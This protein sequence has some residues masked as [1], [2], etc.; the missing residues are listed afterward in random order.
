MNK[1]NLVSPVTLII[2][3]RPDTT[4]IVFRQIAKAKPS[5][6]FVVGDGA[7]TGFDD[8]VRKVSEARKIT[9]SVNWPCA[10]H[11]DFA[12]QN[13]GCKM[14]VVSGLN[15][16]FGMV[17]RTIILEDDVVP[18]LSFFRYCDELL[19]RYANDNRIGMI[20]G[21]N[22]LPSHD[23]VDD[24]SYIYS[25]VPNIPGWGTWARVWNSFDPGVK[26]W[27]VMKKNRVMNEFFFSNPAAAKHWTKIAE[28]VYAGNHQ[29]WDY[30]FS[31]HLFTNNLLTVIPKNNLISNI[32]HGPE[33]TNT[34]DPGDEFANQATV[35]IP[36]PLKHPL[37][38]MPNMSRESTL[39]RDVLG[40]RPTWLR[41]VNKGSRCVSHLMRREWDKLMKEFRFV[42][43]K[44]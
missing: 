24:Y 39:L 31:I 44:Q 13:L 26:L 41:I 20:T 21:T 42:F 10:V 5:R 38:V 16:V 3:N 7:R 35:E 32:G 33:A 12:E 36:F 22:F 28:T 40:I 6:L 2:F 4:E 25:R 29:Y 37:Y 11:Y 23:C 34:K 14:R 8:D 30:Q 9:Q 15:K 19:D 18:D 43:P 1:Y 17:D 27:P